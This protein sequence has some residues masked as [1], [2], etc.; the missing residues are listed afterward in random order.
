MILIINLVIYSL[1]DRFRSDI[2]VRIKLY[3]IE[4]KLNS[5]SLDTQCTAEWY[6]LAYF[7]YNFLCLVYK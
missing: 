2:V 1:I 7:Y 6:P 5:N 3:I 4:F